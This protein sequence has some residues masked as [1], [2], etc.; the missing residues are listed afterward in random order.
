MASLPHGLCFI[1]TLI[2]P[3]GLRC[4]SAGVPF[5]NNKQEHMTQKYEYEEIPSEGTNIFKMNVQFFIYP[6]RMTAAVVLIALILSL[7]EINNRSYKIKKNNRNVFSLEDKSSCLMKRQCGLWPEAF[8]LSAASE[9]KNKVI[10]C[11]WGKWGESGWQHI[12]RL[13][14]FIKTTTVQ[15]TEYL[16]YKLLNDLVVLKCSRP[17][18]WRTATVSIKLTF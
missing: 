1:S 13:T 17:G 7:V 6:V 12:T 5:N 16:S 10:M 11:K 9:K 18:G 8:R 4:C 2:R 14:G 3:A 15:P